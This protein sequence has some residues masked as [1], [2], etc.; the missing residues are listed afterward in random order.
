[1]KQKRNLVLFFMSLFFLLPTVSFAQ[2]SDRVA[3]EKRKDEIK[4]AQLKKSTRSAS[5]IEVEA[6]TDGKTELEVMVTGFNGVAVV[7]LISGRTSS[8]G[9]IDV[10]EMGAEVFSIGT[11]RPGTY[12]LRITVGDEIFEGTFDKVTVGR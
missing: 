4:L 11:F 3:K 6:F 1:M 5:E 2:T 8:R 12:L 7:Q 10:Y 9:F